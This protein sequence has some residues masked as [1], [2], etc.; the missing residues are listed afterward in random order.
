MTVACADGRGAGGGAVAGL[1]GAG[2]QDGAAGM[3]GGA[4]GACG[5]ESGSE[6]KVRA[7]SPGSLSSSHR[8]GA[9]S[10][11][12]DAGP[13]A[14]PRRTIEAGSGGGCTG[15]GVASAARA[16]AE[17]SR[18]TSRWAAW[19]RS[20]P[21]LALRSGP[22]TRTVTYGRLDE[23]EKKSRL[24]H[25]PPSPSHRDGP[26]CVRVLPCFVHGRSAPC[27]PP[28]CAAECSGMRW[29]MDPDSIAVPPPPL[30]MAFSA[31][32]TEGLP[33]W[34]QSRGKCAV[35]QHLAPPSL[36]RWARLRRIS[37]AR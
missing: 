18:S 22:S 25:I 10:S 8:G 6:C 5:G 4:G 33:L 35:R 31:P 21:G 34:S 7:R 1:S 32:R 36:A 12:A 14:T 3:W 26:H 29:G 20:A 23:C 13:G 27:L 19:Q 11:G 37:R 9:S 30:L 24:F 15:D 16:R 28:G 17:P 2:P